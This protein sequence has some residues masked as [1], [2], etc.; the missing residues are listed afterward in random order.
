MIAKQGQPALG[1]I[2]APG[3]PLHPAGNR[4]F[5]KVKTKHEKFSMDARTP[6]SGSP[7]SS[8]RGDPDRMREVFVVEVEKVGGVVPG[9]QN[10]QIL[11]L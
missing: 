5:G 3:H 8:A 2:R 9:F 6:R 1:G 4:S 7:L 11:L 10:G